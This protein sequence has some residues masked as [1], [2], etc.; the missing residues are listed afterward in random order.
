M[1]KFKNF[2]AFAIFFFL[3]STTCFLQATNNRVAQAICQHPEDY[4]DILDLYS[5]EPED[6]YNSGYKTFAQATYVTAVAAATHL[7]GMPFEAGQNGWGPMIASIASAGGG[8]TAFFAGIIGPSVLIAEHAYSEP[9]I[10]IE[11][12]MNGCL[13]KA[14]L[15]GEETENAG[16][17]EITEKTTHNIEPVWENKPH[18]NHLWGVAI[19]QLV[20]AVALPF[21]LCA[22]ASTSGNNWLDFW[23]LELNM[24][25]LLGTSLYG[26]IDGYIHPGDEPVY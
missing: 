20:S 17:I 10:E 16:K 23:P 26:V 19:A 13:P 14:S 4:G 21:T 5:C 7:I 6:V 15:R 3:F 9:D 8:A 25:A 1:F 2:S 12:S 18:T 11:Y 24:L 22:A